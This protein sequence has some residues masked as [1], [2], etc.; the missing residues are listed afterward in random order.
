MKSI[1]YSKCG[2]IIHSVDIRKGK[3]FH[4]FWWNHNCKSYGFSCHSSKP[5]EEARKPQLCP[6]VFTFPSR[7]KWWLPGNFSTA[8]SYADCFM[9]I[10][11]CLALPCIVYGFHLTCILLFFWHHPFF[12]RVALGICPDWSL[13]IPLILRQQMQRSYFIFLLTS[14]ILI[15][16]ETRTGW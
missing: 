11:G 15:K 14:L 3:N 7:G 9:R 16:E 13:D 1:K 4:F 2:W 10:N 6:T 5:S 12:R 8:Q